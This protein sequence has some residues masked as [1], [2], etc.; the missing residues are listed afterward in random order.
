MRSPEVWPGQSRLCISPPQGPPPAQ[1]VTGLF[2]SSHWGKVSCSHSSG[3]SCSKL[4]LKF[5]SLFTLFSIL[6]FSWVASVRGLKLMWINGGGLGV[7]S[8]WYYNLVSTCRPC[9]YPHSKLWYYISDISHYIP[10]TWLLC[11]NLRS[12]RCEGHALPPHTVRLWRTARTRPPRWPRRGKLSR[13][14]PWPSLV[15]HERGQLWRHRETCRS[16]LGLPR[17][18]EILRDLHIILCLLLVSRWKYILTISLWSG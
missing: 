6:L 2:S 1:T 9:Q 17:P 16:V 18:W 14:P 5:Q 8:H 12:W 7:D 15:P 10:L 13:S 11:R 4:E 3:C